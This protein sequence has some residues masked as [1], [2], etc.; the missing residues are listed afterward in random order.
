MSALEALQMLAAGQRPTSGLLHTARLAAYGTEFYGEEA[1]VEAFRRRPQ[2]ISDAVTV[3]AL[4]GHI[5]TFDS[6]TALFA[7]L[8]GKTI[9]RIWRLGD[10]DPAAGEPGISVAF[11]PDLAQ[12]RGDVFAA[13]T[14]HSALETGAFGKVIAAGRSIAQGDF[15]AYRSRAFAL[16]AFGSATEGAALFAVYR[17][18][19]EHARTS[20]FSMSAVRWTNGSL[21]VVRDRAGE[22]ALAEAQ[23]TPGIV[24]GRQED[25]VQ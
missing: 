3:L 18:A 19:G 4:P 6:D 16:R 15:A 10:G 14:D 23:W 8:H 22:A 21:T 24:R 12:A 7:D 11:D 5:A 20:G 1:I 2:A 13:A 17:L 9:A 25:P